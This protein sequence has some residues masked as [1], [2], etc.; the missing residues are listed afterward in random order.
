MFHQSLISNRI[1]A[2]GLNLLL[3]LRG[4]LDVVTLGQHLR[5]KSLLALK[6]RILML[7]AVVWL[8]LSCLGGPAGS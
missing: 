1:V 5:V 6:E 7:D 3:T 8:R 2:K 4:V